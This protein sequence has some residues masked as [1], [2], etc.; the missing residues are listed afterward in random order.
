MSQICIDFGS[1][2]L[3]RLPR[4]G[5]LEIAKKEKREK[6]GVECEFYREPMIA[7]AISELGVL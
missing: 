1:E 7:H 5:G 4:Y 6:R 2:I 3:C